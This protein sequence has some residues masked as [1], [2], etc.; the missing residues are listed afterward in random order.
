MLYESSI[1]SKLMLNLAI[2]HKTPSLGQRQGVS[3]EV[4]AKLRGAY[5]KRGLRY[6]IAMINNSFHQG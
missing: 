4:E 3:K 5:Q 1:K 6:P 2:H